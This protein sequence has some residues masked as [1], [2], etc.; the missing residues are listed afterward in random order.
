[1]KNFLTKS[2]CLTLASNLSEDSKFYDSQN[3][4]VVGKMKVV[5]K[6]IPINKFVGLK[7]K[8]HFMLSM[9]VKSLM[10]QKE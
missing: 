2:I 4:M 10:Q 3:K 1:M 5:Y 8:M 9:M 7:S 6:G